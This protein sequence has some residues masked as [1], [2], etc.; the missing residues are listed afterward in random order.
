[1]PA[2]RRSTGD[3]RARRPPAPRRSSGDSRRA[4][5]SGRDALEPGVPR[6][7]ACRV[8]ARRVGPRR[9]RG[10]CGGRLA[11][12]GRSPRA[13]G[14]ESA[15]PRPNKGPAGQSLT[16]SNTG[17][18][19]A[20]RVPDRLACLEPTQ[21]L[22]PAWRRQALASA[23]VGVGAAIPGS[24]GTAR[25]RGTRACAP[26]PRGAMRACRAACR[27]RETALAR[28]SHAHTQARSRAARAQA[29]AP[30]PTG[31]SWGGKHATGGRRCVGRCIACRGVA[32]GGN[33]APMHSNLRVSNETLAAT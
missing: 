6:G 14:P 20:C 10:T 23:R 18:W 1:M 5:R 2:P 22:P 12:L 9:P 7:L 28:A 25:A 17:W 21:Q 33:E 3:S 24:A 13:F 31:R 8:R 16:G 11:A 15:A 30:A 32:R 27:T 4:A 26:P 29:A 19:W